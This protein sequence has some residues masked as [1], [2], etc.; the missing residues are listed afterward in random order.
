MF[1]I[2]MDNSDISL[3]DF[4]IS[5]KDWEDAEKDY[6]K[7]VFTGHAFEERMEMTAIW[8][9]SKGEYKEYVD[10]LDSKGIN[11]SLYKKNKKIM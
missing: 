8:K 3:L 6:G 10:S 9:V 4:Y 11:W 5:E 2:K 7:Q 1:Q